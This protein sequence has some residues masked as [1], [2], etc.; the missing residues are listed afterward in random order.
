[1]RK[2]WPASWKDMRVQSPAAPGFAED[3]P[4]PSNA[5]AAAA[6]ERGEREE[7]ERNG[8]V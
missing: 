8:S 2:N 4:S 7:R 1:L 6:G 3:S 5:S